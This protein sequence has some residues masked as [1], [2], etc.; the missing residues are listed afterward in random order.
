MW[1]CRAAGDKEG[2]NGQSKEGR[3]ITTTPEVFTLLLVRPCDT[4]RVRVRFFCKLRS[5][6]LLKTT[7]HWRQIILQLLRSEG[8][9]ALRESLTEESK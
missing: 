5:E 3:L 7:R 9:S 1:K 8:N 2:R 4:L 6:S